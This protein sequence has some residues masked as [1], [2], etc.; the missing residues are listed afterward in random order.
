MEHWRELARESPLCEWAGQVMRAEV[1]STEGH[2]EEGKEGKKLLKT[3]T[4]ISGT[5]CYLDG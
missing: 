2:R 4:V 3:L 5:N 1:S